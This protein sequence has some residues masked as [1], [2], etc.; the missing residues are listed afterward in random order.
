MLVRALWHF[1]YKRNPI[2]ERIIHGTTVEIIWTIFPSFILMFIDVPSFALLYSMDKV[3]DPTIT[4]KAIGY[5]W[6]AP[7]HE[8]DRSATKC[9]TLILWSTKLLA[10]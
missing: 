3:I 5:Q 1:H 7:S 8:S 10:Y 9:T 6:Y 2:L 4:I